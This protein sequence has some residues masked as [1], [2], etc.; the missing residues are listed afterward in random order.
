MSCASSR[1]G[2]PRPQE[3]TERMARFEAFKLDCEG[4]ARVAKQHLGVE[5]FGPHIP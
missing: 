2:S 1:A 5:F 3:F 4:F